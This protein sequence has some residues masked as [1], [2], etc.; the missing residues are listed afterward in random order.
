LWVAFS[1]SSGLLSLLTGEI[2]C[3]IIANNTIT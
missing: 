2:S 1:I 3:I